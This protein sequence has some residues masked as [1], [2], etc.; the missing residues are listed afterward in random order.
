MQCVVQLLSS[1]PQSL[2]LQEDEDT[3]ETLRIR[4]QVLKLVC[5]K[6]N[7]EMMAKKN[8]G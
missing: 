2:L 5:E 3:L 8:I 7:R 4:S 1:Q 6:S